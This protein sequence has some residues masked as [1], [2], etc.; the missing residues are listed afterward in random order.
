MIRLLRVILVMAL[1]TVLRVGLVTS[2]GCDGV[3]PDGVESNGDEPN[4][5]EP[6]DFDSDEPENGQPENSEPEPDWT[7]LGSI[8]DC[9]ES[10]SQDL[11]IG[12]P[13]PDFRFQDAI[14]QT[15]SLSDFRGKPVMLN[16]WTTWCT[17]CKIEFPYIQQVYD[18]WQGGEVV[19]LTINLG[20]SS[21]IVT[22]CIEAEGIFLPVLLDKGREVTEQ[23]GVSGIP[24]TFFIDKDGLIQVAKL[25][26]FSDVEEI[27]EIL[28]QLV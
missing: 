12:E 28:S 3:A 16:F 15:F 20:E 10:T 4:G 5:N 18:E 9:D 7:G 2:I 1:V 23:Y 11:Q 22:A 8:I 17:F 19:I 26:A 25:G 24:R 6:D 13:A 27:E 21:E 14:G